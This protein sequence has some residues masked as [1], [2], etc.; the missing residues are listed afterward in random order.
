VTVQKIEAIEKVFNVH[1]PE[2]LAEFR[3][4]VTFVIGLFY[5]EAQ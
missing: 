5:S 2:H 3:E 4:G 1:V